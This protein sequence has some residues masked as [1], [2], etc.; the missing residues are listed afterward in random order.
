MTI[1]EWQFSRVTQG[2]VL[3]ELACIMKIMG[4]TIR[5]GELT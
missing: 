1:W 3:V 4:E 2:G 5:F